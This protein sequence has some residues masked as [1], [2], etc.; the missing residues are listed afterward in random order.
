MVQRRKQSS[1]VDLRGGGDDD[2]DGHENSRRP[3]MQTRGANGQPHILNDGYDTLED[4]ADDD[5]HAKVNQQRL[6]LLEEILLLG[7]K[8]QQVVYPASPQVDLVS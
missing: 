3:S 7:L 6:T 8:D 4:G 2:D 5:K 1:Q